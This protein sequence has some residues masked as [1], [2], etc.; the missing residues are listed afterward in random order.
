MPSYVVVNLG[1]EEKSIFLCNQ[2]INC[3]RNICKQ[4]HKWLFVAS[5]IRGVRY[6]YLIVNELH[7]NINY[8]FIYL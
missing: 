7:Y 2:C 4:V 6:I 1:A 3:T 5:M 8:I